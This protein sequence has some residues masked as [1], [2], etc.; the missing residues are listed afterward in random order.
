VF[1]VDGLVHI[2]RPKNPTAVCGMEGNWP[3]PS[4]GSTD[5]AIAY[6][7][8]HRGDFTQVTCVYCIVWAPNWGVRWPT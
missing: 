1:G 2:S 6:A 7:R 4:M 8:A 5:E 3:I